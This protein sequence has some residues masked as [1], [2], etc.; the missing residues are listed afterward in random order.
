MCLGQRG[1]GHGR[2]TEFAG[3]I[4]HQSTWHTV[5]RGERSEM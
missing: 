2:I 5:F 3:H 1:G 4:M